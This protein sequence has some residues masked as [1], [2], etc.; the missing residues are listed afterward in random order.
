MCTPLL[1][2]VS[3]IGQAYSEQQTANTQADVAEQNAVL[4]QNKIKDVEYQKQQQIAKINRDKQETIGAQR[5]AMA[6]NGVDSSYG[7]G[8]SALTDTA[9]TAQEDINETEYNAEKQG[10]GYRAEATNYRNQASA[11]RTAGRN[12]MVGGVL[13]AA[14][15]YFASQSPVSKK[16]ANRS[17]TN[18]TGK[19]QMRRF[20]QYGG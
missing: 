12:A 14:G 5:A 8:L 18:L 3:T 2:A 11:A 20:A 10:W 9:Y 7:S 1:A 19:Q 6:A 15:Q 17:T 13:G 16:W 4:A